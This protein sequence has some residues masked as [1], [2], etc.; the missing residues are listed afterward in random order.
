MLQMPL[1]RQ[2]KGCWEHHHRTLDRYHVR[3]LPLLHAHKA[4]LKP[5]E[6]LQTLRSFR[7][8]L[9]LFRHSEEG[10]P[11]RDH[12]LSMPCSSHQTLIF[13]RGS[14]SKTSTKQLF[15]HF[16]AVWGQTYWHGSVLFSGLLPQLPCPLP[17]RTS[18][19]HKKNKITCRLSSE[20][21]NA[22]KKRVDRWCPNPAYCPGFLCR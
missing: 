15:S 21:N 19:T 8:F 22:A 2:L 13:C 9:K 20:E 10:K 1:L 7:T 14:P 12:L 18:T 17:Q 6:A 3:K 11:K 16:G 5:V 4:H